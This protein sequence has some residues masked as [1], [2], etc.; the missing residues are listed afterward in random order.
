MLRLFGSSLSRA[1]MKLLPKTSP[2]VA[3]VIVAAGFVAVSLPSPEA[4]FTK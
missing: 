4:S 2:K 3:K 1:R